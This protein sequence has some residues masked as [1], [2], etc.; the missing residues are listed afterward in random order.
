MYSKFRWKGT[1]WTKRRPKGDQILHKLAKKS[2]KG[3][4]YP[5]GDLVFHPDIDLVELDLFLI[6]YLLSKLLAD[7][8]KKKF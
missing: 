8:S 1:F 4:K 5:K 2:P 6:S 3:K 7:R